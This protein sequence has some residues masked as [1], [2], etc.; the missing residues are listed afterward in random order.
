MGM[1]L[2]PF[3]TPKISHISYM[4]AGSRTCAVFDPR[5]DVQVYIDTAHSRGL[6]ITHV[7]ETH[8]H[9]DFVSGHMDLAEKT[10]ATLYAPKRGRCSFEHVPL[11]EGDEV[12][13]EDMVL[14]VV[15]TPGHTPEH[16]SYVVID[17]ARG[18]EPAGVFCGDTLFVGDVGRPDLFPGRADELGRKLYDS[19]HKKL[20]NL[21]DF[22]EMYPL[23]AAGSLCGKAIAS[24][25]SS[26][27][28]YE[29]RFNAA[30]QLEDADRFVASV[31]MDMPPAPDHFARC[32]VV[33]TMGPALVDALP[34]PRMMSPQE[35][36]EAAGNST[37]V[38]DVRPYESFGAMH[39]DGAYSIDLE[40]NF[41]V[42][43]GWLIPPDKDILL[44][45][46]SFEQVQEAVDWLRRVGQDRTAGFLDGGMSAWALA[47]LPARHVP[48][49]SA[50]EFY[51]LLTTDKSLAVLDVRPASDFA[52]GHIK[53]AVNIPVADLRTRHA[54]LDSSR[55]IVV[56]CPGGNRATMGISLLMQHGFE[57]VMNLAGGLTGYAAAGFPYEL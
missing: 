16:V 3:F 50:I 49:L 12:V 5:R 56:V 54:E 13:L 55:P 34:F 20:L 36:R 21:P 41:P 1:L 25:R 42:F 30:L 57:H 15:E 52:A 9:A 18:D 48:Q 2:L 40:T 26:T 45:A 32:T 33:N 11:S 24:K 37:V 53:R 19:L 17:T 10:G 14:Q 43:A 7:L 27:I 8:L 38:L 23:H 35:F 28:G 4:L 6:R 29:R 31:A 22:C 47:G 39:I 46:G 44:V 51:D